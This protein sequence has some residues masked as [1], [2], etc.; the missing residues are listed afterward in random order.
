MVEIKCPHCDE[1]IELD[2]GDLGLFECPLCQEDFEWNPQMTLA[3]EELFRPLDFWIGSLVPFLSTCM[4]LFLSLVLLEGWDILF[5]GMI[6]I[7]L[8]PTIAIGIGIYGVMTMRRLLWLG[9]AASLAISGTIFL[10]FLMFMF[11]S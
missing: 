9:A 10:I 7:G 4:G 6:S 2:D 8:W 3:H 5:G 1:A 11:I